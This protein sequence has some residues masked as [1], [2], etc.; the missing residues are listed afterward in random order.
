MTDTSLRYLQMLKLIPRSP[1]KIAVQSI[2]QKLEA[3]GQPTTPRTV[4][5]DL[6][7]LAAQFDIQGDAAKPQGWQYKPD[8]ALFSLVPPDVQEALTL[9]MAQQHLQ[10]LLPEATLNYLKPWFAAAQDVLNK[11]QGNGGLSRWPDKVRVLA[12]GLPRKS[13]AIKADVYAA[14]TQALLT[15]CKLRVSYQS[16][17]DKPS[18]TRVVMPLAMVLRDRV[19]YL[20]CLFE[21]HTD[22]R[23]LV[24]HRM[25]SAMVQEP[26]VRPADFDLQ[27][28][29]AAGQLGLPIGAGTLE[30]EA[31]F[32]AH[33][34]IHLAESPIAD[35]QKLSEP[36]D[37]AVCLRATVPDNLELRLWLQSFGCE[38]EVTAPESLR[39]EFRETAEALAGFYADD[40]D[41]DD[42]QDTDD[43][44]AGSD[45]PDADDCT[46]K[47]A[48]P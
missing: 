9:C 15:D 29:I 31:W 46:A 1:H 36:E 43:S 44:E 38:V 6:N 24:L 48:T 47:G 11:Q 34:A 17:G 16:V 22:V 5:R 41:D 40:Q 27:V 26:F 2:Q 13:P 42:D 23:Q 4:Q 45:A 18:W 3:M 28:N 14:I 19:V 25:L 20:Q 8:A 30:L 10:H 39:Q 35:D 21:G 7:L 37:G 12:P 32:D 33:L